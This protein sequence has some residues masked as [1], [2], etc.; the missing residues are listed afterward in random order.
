M[1][2][3]KVLFLM[4]SESDKPLVEASI[5]YFEYFK[6]DVELKISSAHRNPDQTARIASDARTNGYSAVICAAGMAAH[7]AGVVAAHSDLP[8]L[9]VPLPGGVMDGMDSLLSTVQMPKGI[10]VATFA[11]GKAG[12]INAAVFC[13][14]MLSAHHPEIA[15]RYTTFRTNGYK[16][17]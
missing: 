11:V 15:S 17:P 10:P 2:S 16:L 6:I 13:A 12:V 4:G 1:N 5:P 3:P 7:L 8:V 14:R 9:G